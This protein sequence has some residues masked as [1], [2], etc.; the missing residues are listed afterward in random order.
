MC[1]GLQNLLGELLD[2]RAGDTCRVQIEYRALRPG[3]LGE[4]HALAERALQHRH[5]IDGQSIGHFAAN[6]S[7]GD[8]YDLSQ[9]R[10]L[11]PV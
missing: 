11:G 6:R 8:F 1:H 4:C 2:F 5:P 10:F 9:M 7:V 3:T